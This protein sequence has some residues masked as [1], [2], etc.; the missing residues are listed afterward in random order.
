MKLFRIV[1]IVTIYSAIL[2]M[3]GCGSAG[4]EGSAL[5]TVFSTNPVA[6][7][8]AAGPT[9]AA[10]PSGL[11]ATAFSSGQINLAWA[12]NSSNESGFR[13]ERKTGIDGTYAEITTTVPDIVSYSD[14]GLAPS[15]I[16]Y[17]R[18]RSTNSVG[19]SSYTTEVHATT[20]AG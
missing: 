2:L 1:S 10:A 12:D 15:T 6:P 5:G 20:P 16:Y 4:S 14:T 17:Y 7:P 19:D 9:V 11:S 13:I 8:P 18:I 3:S